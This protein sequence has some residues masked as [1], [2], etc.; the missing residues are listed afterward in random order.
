M[1]EW[2]RGE[3]TSRRLSVLIGGLPEGSALHRAMH[4]G[5]TWTTTHQLLWLVLG[6]A[7]HHGSFWRGFLKIKSAADKWKWPKTPW[8]K[9][10]N[11]AQYGRVAQADRPA[12]ARYL[13]GLY[14][15]PPDD[16]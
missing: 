14:A 1:G 13:I 10:D 7:H 16:D 9:Q 3:I 2:Y 6:E 5:K 4:D 12:A 15:P 11:G 8:E